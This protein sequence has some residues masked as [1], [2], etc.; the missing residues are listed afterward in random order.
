M[1]VAQSFSRENG[2]KIYYSFIIIF[3]RA[4]VTLVLC[5]FFLGGGSH[6]EGWFKGGKNVH[7]FRIRLAWVNKAEAIFQASLCLCKYRARN[8]KFASGIFVC[9]VQ[10]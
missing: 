5:N 4:T 9:I 3:A 2:A 8:D 6:R 7:I 10:C 1:C